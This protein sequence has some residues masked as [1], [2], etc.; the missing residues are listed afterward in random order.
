MENLNLLATV[1]DAAPLILPP[2]EK[3]YSMAY[4]ATVAVL[5]DNIRNDNWF[6]PETIHKRAMAQFIVGGIRPDE[7]TIRQK[8]QELLKSFDKEK[9]HAMR[10]KKLASEELT[11]IATEMNTCTDE[12]V[13]YW[14]KQSSICNDSLQL[15]QGVGS[16]THSCGNPLKCE[17]FMGYDRHYEFRH[18]NPPNGICNCSTYPWAGCDRFLPL[19]EHHLQCRNPR[20]PLCA[21]ANRIGVGQ[22][23]EICL[24][25]FRKIP[26]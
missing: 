23:V 9:L 26:A 15:I 17:M 5:I 25:C 10:N 7:D 13:I 14:I 22:G 6:P 21:K 12:D 18:L 11:G 19:W 16:V 24:E 1:A 3:L 8:T 20:C 4:P 2:W